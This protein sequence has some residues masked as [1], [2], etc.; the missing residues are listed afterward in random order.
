MLTASK[1]PSAPLHAS[2]RRLVFVPLA[3]IVLLF[4]FATLLPHDARPLFFRLELAASELL[5]FVGCVIAATAFERGDYL[6]RAWSYTALCFVLIW[7]SDLSRFPELEPLV[8]NDLARGVVSLIGNIVAILGAWRFGRAWS[9]ADLPDAD[10]TRKRVYIVAA[11][12]ALLMA[13]GP[14]VNDVEAVVF[15]DTAALVNVASELGDIGSLCVMAPILPVAFALRGGHLAWPWSLLSASLIAW[16]AF[17]GAV[18]LAGGAYMTDLPQRLFVE[19]FRALGCL[20]T[21]AAGIAQRRVIRLT[22]EATQSQL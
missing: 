10:R 11:I 14:L 12:V 9:E 4:V 3:W 8:G 18:A 20:L 5:G 2:L 1:S 22:R 13:G 16:L 15:G 19:V 7:L 6:R 17:D 21:L